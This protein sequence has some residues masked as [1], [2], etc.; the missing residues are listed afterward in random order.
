MS[1][2][3]EFVNF[4]ELFQQLP[5]DP[6]IINDISENTEAEKQGLK[7]KIFTNYDS[8]LLSN[9]PAC[10]CGETQAAYNIGVIC[11]NCNTPVKQA[12]DIELQ[13]LLWIRSPHGVEKLINPMIWHML[14]ERFMV[15]TFDT[16]QWICNT[17]Y[18]P[19]VNIPKGLQS[20]METGMVRGYNHFV[21]NFFP[22]VEMMFNHKAFKAKNKDSNLL[23]LL[24]RERDS[25][26]CSYIPVVNRALL[27]IEKSMVGIY[28]D[29]HITE[30]IDAIQTIASIDV[31]L[32]KHTLRAKE[33][34]TVKTLSGLSTFY[35]NYMS[36]HLS[37]KQG[38]LR[39]HTYGSRS[40]FSF[41]AVV[42]SITEPHD[43]DEIHIPWPIAISVFR[44]HL[45]NILER[46]GYTPNGALDLINRHAK[47]YHPL[48]DEIFE[49][50]I[51]S[52]P[53]RGIYTTLNRNPSLARGSI[54]RVRITKIKKDP[55][56]PTV[57]F[58]ILIVTPLNADFD[59]DALNFTLTLDDNLSE[60]FKHLQPH[61]SAF[62]L[63]KPKTISG[64]MSMPKTVVAT[65][66]NWMHSDVPDSTQMSSEFLASVSA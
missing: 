13:P 17:S 8:D 54:Q 34:R 44:Y 5:H 37:S 14:R 4:N 20:F 24:H 48:L 61:K 32:T 57:S 65:I 66:S 42:T 3:L 38:M 60:L 62:E 16:M 52:T 28:A 18:R 46:Y 41:R 29:K 27:V 9:V 64:N 63:D 55:S 1:N 50:M 36:N 49:K 31:T 6:I 51:A 43:L 25:I 22:I 53:H 47:V 30:A 40:N 58:S 2:H 35:R 10:D 45:L 12:L 33:N 11:P 26:F 7:D 19:T 56:I 15:S 23:K 21:Q 39:Q 59:G